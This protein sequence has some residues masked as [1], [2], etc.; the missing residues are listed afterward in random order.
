MGMGRIAEQERNVEHADLGQG[1]GQRR[2]GDESEID[3]AELDALEHFHLAAERR[4]GELLDGEPAAGALRQLL[5]ERGGA[6]AELRFLR[7]DV[8]DLQS[9]R[10]GLSRRGREGRGCPQGK[11][12]RK[13]RPAGGKKHGIFLEHEFARHRSLLCD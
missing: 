10:L 8:T 7:Q 12:E 6:G 11:R 13:R 9:T 1:V 2:A 4:V 3:G 5:G